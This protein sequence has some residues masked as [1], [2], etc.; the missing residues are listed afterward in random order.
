MY[1]GRGGV[2]TGFWWKKPER[3]SYLEDQGVDRRIILNWML[4]IFIWYRAL[5]ITSEFFYQLI[6]YLVNI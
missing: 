4:K 5:L 6:H 2:R 3:K 1:R